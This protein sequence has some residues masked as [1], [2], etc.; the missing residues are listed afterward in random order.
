MAISVSQAFHRTSANPIDETMTLTKAQMLLVNDNLMPRYYL[1][2]CQDDGAIYLYDKSATPSEECGKFH[3]L[4]AGEN[5][6]NNDDLG[7]FVVGLYN[8][9]KLNYAVD[10]YV[11]YLKK[12][13][14]CKVANTTN[15]PTVTTDWEQVNIINTIDKKV[16]EHVP[17]LSDYVNN[18]DLGELV[19]ELYDSTKVDYAVDDYVVYQKKLYRCKTANTRNLPTNTTDWE[20]VNLIDTIDKKVNEHVPDLSNYVDNEDLGNLIVAVYDSTASY[21]VNDFCIHDKK[22]YQCNTEITSGGETWNANHWTEVTIID[23]MD[24][25]ISAIDLSPFVTETNL[26]NIIASNWNQATAYAVGSYVLYNREIYRCKSATTS[27]SAWDSTKWD[28]ITLVDIFSGSLPGLVPAATQNDSDKLL[29]SDGNW[30]DTEEI[31]LI[32]IDLDSLITELDLGDVVASIY[33]DTATY[34]LDSYVIHEHLLYRCTT[35]IAQAESWDST[36]W[37][38][39]SITGDF[40][41][42]INLSGIVASLYDS[43]QTYSV[44][45]FVVHDKKLYRCNTDISVAESWDNTHWTLVSLTQIF[46]GSN[47]GLVPSASVAD[48]NKVLTGAGTWED[49]VTVSYNA[50]T[51]ELSLDFSIPSQ[52]E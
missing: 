10:D 7:E 25:K 9:E 17:D 35:A 6:V 41:N 13:Y 16:N 8:P 11:I 12:L 22:F 15:L 29:G 1:T 45:D 39:V 30:K 40:I 33:D 47:P 38:K 19:V 44:N 3:K 18:D 36:H 51:E 46:N 26:N 21:N 32:E 2:I 49:I 27:G 43:T 31:E 34:A 5:Y 20:K 14:R 24:V 52:S 4:E 37:T 23:V 48:A 50:E 42:E 28:K